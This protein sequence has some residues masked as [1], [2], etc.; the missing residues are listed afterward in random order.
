MQEKCA[1]YFTIL[2]VWGNDMKIHEALR[3][4]E[5]GNVDA[6]ISI[7]E[8]L[9]SKTIPWQRQ[10]GL[11][12]C[13]GKHI[14]NYENEIMVMLSNKRHDKGHSG[15]FLE[16]VWKYR[17]TSI[18]C[19]KTAWRRDDDDEETFLVHCIEYSWHLRDDQP[20]INEYRLDTHDVYYQK[21]CRR[22]R[23]IRARYRD[24]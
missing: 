17:F 19:N 12:Y 5:H 8:M 3:R 9:K 24:M 18:I 1:L 14:Q 13:L 16:P 15:L 10:F 21:M 6:D 2:Y 7:R 20:L 23:S 11:V 4:L 22:A